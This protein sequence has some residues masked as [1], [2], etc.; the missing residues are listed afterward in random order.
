MKKRMWI[1]GLLVFVTMVPGVYAYEGTGA[2]TFGALAPAV[3]VFAGEGLPTRSVR[4]AVRIW[5]SSGHANGLRCIR[6]PRPT[7]HEHCMDRCSQLASDDLAEARPQLRCGI[8]AV[9]CTCAPM[10]CGR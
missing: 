3:P 2:T 6:S 10:A 7:G 5:A 1:A 8:E 9:G 4:A